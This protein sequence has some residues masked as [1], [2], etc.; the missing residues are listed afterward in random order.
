MTGRIARVLVE[1]GQTVKAGEVLAEVESLE[2]RNV[3]LDLLCTQSQLK[4]SRKVL[5]Q[6][7]RLNMTGGIAEK[8]LWETQTENENLQATVNSLKHKLSLMGL[9]DDEI[10][11]IASLDITEGASSEAFRTT[12]AIRS[13]IDGRITLFDLSIGQVVRPQ[14]QLFEVHDTPTRRGA[15]LRTRAG[16]D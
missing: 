5:E 11:Q 15:G 13:P 14:D 10:E 4:L 12:C 2:L 16:L 7:R 6:Y 1:H 8:D 3:Q 9:A